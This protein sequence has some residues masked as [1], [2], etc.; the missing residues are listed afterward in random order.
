MR[1]VKAQRP[2]VKELNNR[3]IDRKT[4]AW[5]KEGVADTLQFVQSALTD[6]T[7]NSEDTTP[8]KTC[9]GALHR[10]KGAVEMVEIE[11]AK[12]LAIELELLACALLDEQVKHKIEAAEVLA[13]G[14]YQLTGYLESLYHGQPDLPL[15]LLPILN[16]CRACQGKALF[17]EGDFFV[18]KCS[19][20]LP[21]KPAQK[22][23]V[24]GDIAVVAK[25]LRPGY[26]SG[27]LGV[28]KQDREVENLE[29]LMFVLENLLIASTSNESHQFWWVSLGLVDSLHSKDVQPS[30]AVKILLGRID[31]EI[32][33]IIT[34]GEQALSTAPPETIIKNLLYYVAQSPSCSDRVAGIKKAFQLGQVDEH[35]IDK[36]RESL[37]GFNVNMVE[38]VADQLKEEL[39]TI[40]DEL[41]ITK[42]NRLGSAEGL[43]PILKNFSTVSDI[44]NM[45]GM[46]KQKAVLDA[47]KTLLA[48]KIAHHEVL[49][50]E[51]LMDIATALLHVESSIT[52]LARSMLSPDDLGGIPPAEY[53]SMMKVV[54]QEL[55]EI[56]RSIK[57]SVDQ[58]S[59]KG[60]SSIAL[61]GGVPD[62]LKQMAG[63]MHAINDDQQANLADAINQYVCQELI[64]NE[65]ESSRINLDLLA[66]A[67]TG[68]ENYYQA[69]LEESVAP[70]LGL[71]V[72]SQSITRLGFPPEKISDH[73]DAYSDVA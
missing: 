54:A 66:D 72:A 30:V 12:I 33:R 48:E 69:L 64:L 4:L 52:H 26:L 23:V 18:P 61:L 50:D 62:L 70:E 19:V 65:N 6:F 32:Y 73:Y 42:R 3:A 39:L 57:E 60:S 43:A 55:L 21:E 56:L 5:I 59:V 46:A 58:Y 25:K 9:I 51:D 45:L 22:C 40:K 37:Y 49:S 2:G 24:A 1:Y 47:Q 63:A 7:A 31:R 44:L 27:L 16:D 29:K 38:S 67:I 41:D 10:V 17:S 71:K 14:M 68:L 53:E 28:I 34:Q 11:G 15:I 36:A 8:I 20:V 13:A 35:E